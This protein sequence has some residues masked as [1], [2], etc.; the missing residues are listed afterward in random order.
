[1][2]QYL[3]FLGLSIY[4]QLFG[5][6]EKNQ[7]PFFNEA[8]LSLNHRPP[9]SVQENV[10]GFGGGLYHVFK[11]KK[12]LHWVAGVAYNYNTIFQYH[13]YAG[14]YAHY[15]NILYKLNYASI[16]L[17][18]RIIL[19]KKI[20]VFAEPGVF[21]DISLGGRYSG[22]YVNYAPDSNNMFEYKYKAVS[23]KTSLALGNPG[24]SFALGGSFPIQ[25]HRLSVK[26]EYKIGLVPLYKYMNA[27]INIFYRFTVAYS[28]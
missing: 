21:L 1:M 16:P 25:K 9:L 6:E 10:W 14:H 23:G 8:Q 7:T 11:N 12:H 24:I 17:S 5:Q 27:I 3:L 13:E 4:I 20:Q 2:K 15:E 19:G 22:T 18:A 28:W 26:G